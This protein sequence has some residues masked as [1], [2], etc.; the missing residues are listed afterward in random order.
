MLFGLDFF[1]KRKLP[2]GELV[3]PLASPSPFR[4]KLDYFSKGIDNV[5]IDAALSPQFVEAAT[6]LVRMAIQHDISASLPWKS[7]WVAPP[8]AREFEAFQRTYVGIM[9][10]ALGMA[11]KSGRREPVQL[12]EFA[13]LKFLLGLVGQE[14]IRLREDLQLERAYGSQSDGRAMRIYE[15]L[16]SLAHETPQAHH[17]VSQKLLAQVLNLESTTLRKRRKSLLGRSWAVPRELLFNP[18]LQLPS[19]WTEELIMRSHPP[20][21]VGRD[22]PG[23]FA[24]INQIVVGM[25]ADYLPDW[26]QPP[27][28]PEGDSESDNISS[29]LRTDQGA[30]PGFLDVDLLLDRALR[31]EEYAQSRTSWLDDP[32]NL[33][34]LLCSEPAEDEPQYSLE[35]SLPSDLPCD[36]AKHL[37]FRHYFLKEA[38]CRFQSAGLLDKI[39]AA[40]EAPTIYDQ[41]GG[42]LP[43]RQIIEYLSGGVSRR[44]MAKRLS[45]AK[46]VA[47][48]DAALKRLDA[49]R[50]A[51]R[52]LGQAERLRRTADFIVGFARLRRDLKLAHRAY[53][54]MDQIRI[55]D[56]AAHIELARRNRTLNEFVLPEEQPHDAEDICG[57]A[58]IKADLRGSSRITKE[59]RKRNLNPATHF[60]LNFFTPINDLLERFG[61]KKVFVEGD[62]VILSVYEHENAA[63][64]WLAVSRAAGLARKILEV[65]D[66]QNA[67]NRK[68]GLPELELGLGIAY[69]PEAPAFLYDGDREIVIS[70]AINRADR[71]SSCAASLRQT[72]LGAL[73]RGVEVAVPVGQGI[74]QKDSGD[75]QL[76]HNVN[77]IELDAAAFPKLQTELA[78]QRVEARFPQYSPKSLF[79]VGRYS[80]KTGVMHWLI[81]REAPVRLWIGNDTS[82][83]EMGGRLFYEI[84]TD[85][86]VT[87]TLMEKLV[88]LGQVSRREDPKTMA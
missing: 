52:R 48:A 4:F 32:G 73:A 85:T 44:A 42:Q 20:L 31:R 22:Q 59:L 55:L 17:R 77:G 84:V 61:A 9:D 47:D 21:G 68:H 45:H 78:L 43:V 57:H 74:M 25:L 71:L 30:L 60:T 64:D 34:R 75:N 69:L 40:H 3:A 35:S 49:G 12:A 23:E 38:Q 37:A 28:P 62:A 81:V 18:I 6:R 86:E 46:T 16:A 5:H 67:Q 15:L 88:A 72:K 76:R 1:L 63:H 65:V 56:Q 70:S 24:E 8:G 7:K 66:A 83:E 51:I 11:R 39:H 53:W 13:A 26:T 79:Y 27:P 19:P 10:T 41:L 82:I 33:K 54:I 58:I 80:D 2:V 14:L 29:R 36:T 50:S 87:K